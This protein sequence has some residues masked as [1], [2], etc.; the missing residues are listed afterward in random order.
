MLGIIKVE[1]KRNIGFLVE[2]KAAELESVKLLKFAQIAA[3]IFLNIT[4]I[5]RKDTTQNVK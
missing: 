4:H 1:C 5:L 2:G 3:E